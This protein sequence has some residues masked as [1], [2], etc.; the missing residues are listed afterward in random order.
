MNAP[1]STTPDATGWGSSM[2]GGDKF[3]PADKLPDAPP[4]FAAPG[5]PANLPSG[6]LDDECVGAAQAPA[7]G[8]GGGDAHYGG[9]PG[10]GGGG[11]GASEGADD[12]GGAEGRR[13]AKV[14]YCLNKLVDG[15]ST[16][17]GSKYV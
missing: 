1:S 17:C 10:G 7:I 14:R 11:G 13:A 5:A 8:F 16:F 2:I 12:S 4:M 6:G 3:V 9:A 15:G